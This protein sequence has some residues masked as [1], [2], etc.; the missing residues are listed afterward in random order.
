MLLEKLALPV[1]GRRARRLRRLAAARRRRRLLRRGDPRAR[2]PQHPRRA[3]LRGRAAAA[4]RR[5]G[6]VPRLAEPARGRG[7]RRAG[8][9]RRR[10]LPAR[11][12]TRS[13]SSARATCSSRPRPAAIALLREDRETAPLPGG[14]AARR[15]GLAGRRAATRCSAAFLAARV[16]GRP[17]EDALRAAVAAGAASTLELGAG[18]FDPREA[19]RLQRRRRGERA[20]R[21]SADRDRPRCHPA[22]SVEF[23]D[24]RREIRGS[25]AELSRSE[26]FAQ[27]GPHLRRRAARAGRVG[28]AAE[29]RLDR[30]AADAHDRARDPDRLGG[31]GH[32][33]RG[34]D[35]D[36]ARARGRDR[37]RPPQ[38]LDRRAGGRGRQ[39]QALRVGDDRR[40]AHAAADGAR[41]RRARR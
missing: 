22:R 41:R 18:R 24:G 8:V 7:A 36:R 5:G 17:P 23:P 3:R 16:A 2:P 10:G 25:T 30:D 14:R 31:D 40:A 27:G 19:H 15:A 1:A 11:R 21:P 39:G 20:A 38:P 6:A 29:R 37:D 12:S 4:R 26:K 35:G 33:H 9:P 34:A 28:G 13:P 32:G